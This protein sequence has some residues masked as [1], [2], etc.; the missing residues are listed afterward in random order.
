MRALRRVCRRAERKW[1]KD[2]LTVS[3]EI[4]RTSLNNYQKSVKAAKSK[5][6]SDIISRNCHRPRVLFSTINSIINL[7]VDFHFDE[8]AIACENFHKFFTNKI[9]N[10]RQLIIPADY[11][12]SVPPACS[13]SFSEF[14]PISIVPLREYTKQLKPT[15]S[16]TDIIP[17]RLFMKNLDAVGPCILDII[18]KILSEGT[19]PEYFK[20]A[21]IKPLLKKHNSD[22]TVLSKF[23]PI[24]NLPFISKM[25]ENVVFNQLMSYL[26]SNSVF[27]TFQSGFRKQHSTESALLRVLND[28]LLSIDTGNSVVLLLLD[29]SAAFDTVD[30]SILISRLEHCVGIGGSVLKWFRS[31]LNNI[32]FSVCMDGCSSSKSGLTCGVPQGSILAPIFFL[33]ICSHWVQFLIS[34]KCRFIAMLMTHKFVFLI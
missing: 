32:T 16:L 22:M 2:K 18:N 15:T 20:H 12:S 3:L 10:I 29:L 28:I 14:E 24:S 13:S 5:Y 9:S 27:E 25:L 17:T 30:H 31:F 4:L 26:D 21:T 23:R 19:V 6:F 1:E 11:D 33:C 34:T 7:S 8:P